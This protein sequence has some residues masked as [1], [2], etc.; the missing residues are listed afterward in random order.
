VRGSKAGG[1]PRGLPRFRRADPDAR[2]AARMA[3]PAGRFRR[4]VGGRAWRCAAEAGDAVVMTAGMTSPD[5]AGVGHR[6][7]P[8]SRS[9]ARF[10]FLIRSETVAAK[11]HTISP[12]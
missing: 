5:L 4:A 3:M 2:P 12:R 6:L 7:E 10:P 1:R 8:D 9:Q 11:G